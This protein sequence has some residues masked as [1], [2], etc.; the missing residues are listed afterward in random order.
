MTQQNNQS[1][2]IRLVD[3]HSTR[4]AAQQWRL[5]ILWRFENQTPVPLYIL[6]A[7]PLTT[8]VGDPLILDHTAHTDAL[9]TSPNTDRGFEILTIPPVDML[10]RQLS[11]HLSLPGSTFTVIGRF[12]YGYTAPDP[13]WQQAKNWSQVAAWQRIADSNGAIIVCK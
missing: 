10:E 11:Y 13:A 4:Q 7:L 5:D 2:E 9:P 6:I 12:A 3:H 8:I 1:P